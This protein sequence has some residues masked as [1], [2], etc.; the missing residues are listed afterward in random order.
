VIDTGAVPPPVDDLPACGGFP[1]E[2]CAGR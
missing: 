1:G 2:H